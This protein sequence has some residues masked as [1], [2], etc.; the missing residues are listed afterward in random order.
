MT[1]IPS[2]GSFEIKLEGQWVF[3]PKGRVGQVQTSTTLDWDAPKHTI[4]DRERCRQF[5]VTLAEC[6]DG[7]M[8]FLTRFAHKS[9]TL[10]A[11]DLVASGA[12][13]LH[14]PAI[15]KD[16]LFEDV[17][18]RN[19][20]SA[21][22]TPFTELRPV[23]QVVRDGFL[24]HTDKALL[25]T[26]ILNQVI[27]HPGAPRQMIIMDELPSNVHSSNVPHS[28]SA[29]LVGKDNVCPNVVVIRSMEQLTHPS[30][31]RALKVTPLHLYIN[32]SVV[33]YLHAMCDTEKM[34]GRTLNTI[35]PVAYK[36]ARH[37]LGVHTILSDMPWDRVIT[38]TN[39]S[40]VLLPG[41]PRVGFWWTLCRPADVVGH[42]TSLSDTSTKPFWGYDKTFELFTRHRMID[43]THAHE[44]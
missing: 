15:N 16:C 29:S 22:Y 23:T 25:S 4:I 12:A 38:C 33:M 40:S 19:Y 42:V 31:R 9:V 44:K 41:K 27:A 3:N 6:V 24:T 26:V 10:S 7:F 32:R 36:W 39:M 13:I 17:M 30:I 1:I 21:R 8:A 35:G 14:C 18:L 11:Q 5:G 37:I 43:L 28:V 20:M 34:G 2:G